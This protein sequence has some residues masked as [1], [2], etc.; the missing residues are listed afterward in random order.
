MGRRLILYCIQH[1]GLS[2]YIFLKISK[3]VDGGQVGWSVGCEADWAWSGG[4]QAGIGTPLYLPGYT[5]TGAVWEVVRQQPATA[6]G[7]AV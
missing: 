7:P 1:S 3:Q 6:D 4:T 5:S 2:C